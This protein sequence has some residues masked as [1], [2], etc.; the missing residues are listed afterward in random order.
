MVII[1]QG[2]DINGGKISGVVRSKVFGD[3]LFGDKIPNGKNC[4]LLRG[5]NNDRK[6][7]IV[8]F[9]DGVVRVTGC[10]YIKKLDEYIYLS[11]FTPSSNSKKTLTGADSAW[12]GLTA[13]IKIDRV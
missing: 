4:N 8:K 10:A 13:E 6:T 7:K 11:P 5:N 12:L 1:T 3:I 2:I 9:Q